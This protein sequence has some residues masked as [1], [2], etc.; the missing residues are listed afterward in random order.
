[1]SECIGVTQQAVG[2]L[3]CEKMTIELDSKKSDRIKIF[4]DGKMI[5]QVSSFSL[6]ASADEN[7]KLDM[8]HNKTNPV[9]VSFKHDL[10]RD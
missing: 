2:V 1:M 3:S 6:S 7:I 8:V 10:H 9:V 4:A 5:G